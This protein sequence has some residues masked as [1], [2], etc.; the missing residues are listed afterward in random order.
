[1]MKYGWRSTAID[2]GR[3]WSRVSLPTDG[4]RAEWLEPVDLDSL[5]PGDQFY[6][7]LWDSRLCTLKSARF[8]VERF[9]NPTSGDVGQPMEAFVIQYPD[10]V[11]TMVVEDEDYPTVFVIPSPTSVALECY[12]WADILGGRDCERR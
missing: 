5:E 10:G 9:P 8:K 4:D 6:P 1:M 11:R 12:R 2:G 7:W 3:R